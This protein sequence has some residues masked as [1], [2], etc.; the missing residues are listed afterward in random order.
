MTAP[1]APRDVV[2]RR[3]DF[4]AGYATRPA[5]VITLDKAPSFDPH[6]SLT[7]YGVYDPATKEWRIWFEGG[8]K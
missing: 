3:L 8:V 1:T 7:F 6:K 4:P 5:D 2:G